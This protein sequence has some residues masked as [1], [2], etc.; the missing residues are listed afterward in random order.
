M[1]DQIAILLKGCFMKWNN[2]KAKS[3]R[4]GERRRVSHG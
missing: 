3:T 4:S 1:A 2:P